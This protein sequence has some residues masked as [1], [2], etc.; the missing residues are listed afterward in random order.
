MYVPD[1]QSCQV[2]NSL[3][4]V[5]SSTDATDAVDSTA[6]TSSTTATNPNLASANNAIN[7]A[8][9]AFLSIISRPDLNQNGLPLSRNGGRQSS[10][11]QGYYAWPDYTEGNPK[12]PR[13]SCIVQVRSPRPIA[14]NRLAANAEPPAP[15]MFPL[16]I[17]GRAGVTGEA[18]TQTPSNNA[19]P[20]LGIGALLVGL[21][22]LGGRR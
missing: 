7:N 12:G 18:P 20:L 14:S 9:A 21:W 3:T 19:L 11:F 4:T 16:T 1:T 15:G 6:T 5:S 8:N 22:F 13:R 17:E 2:V 10:P